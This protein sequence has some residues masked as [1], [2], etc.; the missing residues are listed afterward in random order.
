MLENIIA[1]S[2]L[3]LSVILIRAIFRKK[4]PARI[5]YFLWVIVLIKLC[6]PF[7]FIAIDLPEMPW[8]STEQY[9]YEIK[10]DQSNSK[11][12]DSLLSDFSSS[13]K[14]NNY[15]TQ[16]NETDVYN[17]SESSSKTNSSYDLKNIIFLVWFLG[18]IVILLSV[19]ISVMVFNIKLLKNRIYHSTH[20]KTKVYVSDTIASPC[21][22]GLI[23]TI[24]ITTLAATSDKVSLVI[25]HEKTHI[26]HWDHVWSL[27]R[28]LTLIV[29]WWNPI[30]WA[31]VLLSKRDSELACDETVISKM[32]DE[33]RLTY[34]AM[35]VDMIPKKANIAVA[36]SNEPIKERIDMLM[37]THTKKI[38][39]AIIALT[40]V[41]FCFGCANISDVEKPNS[42]G[43]AANENISTND[44]DIDTTENKEKEYKFQSVDDWTNAENIKSVEQYKQL[45]VEDTVSYEVVLNTPQR[46]YTI[47]VSAP[48]NYRVCSYPTTIHFPE[49]TPF[50]ESYASLFETNDC[51]SVTFIDYN[52]MELTM[53]NLLLPID[54]IMEILEE[55]SFIN[56][57]DMLCT[58]SG[59]NSYVSFLIAEKYTNSIKGIAVIDAILDLSAQYYLNDKS[60]TLL[61]AYLG[62]SPED[63][64]TAYSDRSPI[65]HAA[66][67]KCPVLIMNYLQN[68][69][70]SV[71]QANDMKDTLNEA[72]GSCQVVTFD[73]MNSDF[74]S[75]S[76]SEMLV[77]FINQIF[78]E[79]DEL[80]SN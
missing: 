42:P 24:Y 39:P 7:G 6:I 47:Y 13:D 55:C 41:I 58:A 10:D 43:N 19:T 34:A 53:E 54:S 63:N 16:K 78:E 61:E 27:I 69:D 62:A 37:K 22:A 35:I 74:H 79:N 9:N 48:I 12:D 11:L 20:G 14:K 38:I 45:K 36:F 52:S 31:S 56:T 71:T 66:N 64:I 50:H 51:I 76:A 46:D 18:S 49:I 3:A 73:E 21:V 28:A 25:L 8:E 75:N 4:I 80:I 77:S 5:T 44:T 1:L 67:I 30:I 29:Y 17:S 65:T 68:P 32:N 23:P 33:D 70:F 26:K 72:G 57:E 15:G 60:A 40:L 2:L 59:I